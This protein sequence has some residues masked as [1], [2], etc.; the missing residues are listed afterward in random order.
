MGGLG[1]GEQFGVEE[2]KHGTPH[3]NMHTLGELGV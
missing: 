2:A 1:E 3:F